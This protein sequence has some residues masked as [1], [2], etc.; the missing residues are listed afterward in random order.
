MIEGVDVDRDEEDAENI[1][2]PAAVIPS[3]VPAEEGGLGNFVFK[4]E[5]SAI[6]ADIMG[7]K[8]NAADEE[9]D[10]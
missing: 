6:E 9:Y 4:R 2:A 3:G 5:N 1:Y 7:Q 10:R 8:C